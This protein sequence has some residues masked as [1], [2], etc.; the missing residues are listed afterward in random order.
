MS[1]NPAKSPCPPSCP[2]V[3]E[4]LR[5]AINLIN[6]LRKRCKP[7][8]IE[9]VKEL[10]NVTDGIFPREKNDVKPRLPPD[11]ISRD[12]PDEAAHVDKVPV[13]RDV[14]PEVL[15]DVETEP[16]VS[17]EFPTREPTVVPTEKTA[18]DVGEKIYLIEKEK[19]TEPTIVQ[20]ETV[21]VERIDRNEKRNDFVEEKELV[22]GPAVP[23][24]TVTP[25]ERLAD[26]DETKI[27]LVAEKELVEEPTIIPEETVTPTE[28]IVDL[29]EKKIDFVEEEAVTP[30]T[31]IDWEEEKIDLITEEKLDKKPVTVQEETVIPTERTADRDDEKIDFVEEED[32]AVEGIAAEPVRKVPITI[33]EPEIIEDEMKLAPT[34]KIELETSRELEEQFEPEERMEYGEEEESVTDYEKFID[35]ELQESLPAVIA[36]EIPEEPRAVRREISRNA[37]TLYERI[38]RERP[39][40]PPREREAVTAMPEERPAE[41]EVSARRALESST[42]EQ[43]VS[44][45]PEKDACEETCPLAKEQKE[46]IMRKLKVRQRVVDHYYL[47]K[48]FSYFED[49]CTCSLACMVYTLS[50]DPFVKSI[51]ASLAL[52][53]V[54]LKLCSELDAWEMP[55]RVS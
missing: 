31:K 43:I 24:E 46:R 53:A 33:E 32:R 54:G 22:P 5:I 9:T 1:C 7:S 51:F 30:P 4:Q 28:K 52:F 26:R 55:S 48:G 19:L 27:G 3:K 45:K 50:R 2:K 13:D 21:T 35:E 16:S 12:I 39:V 14:R 17:E 40:R 25:T 34:T 42:T 6:T 44:R 38:D 47:T 41:E 8:Q 37:A 11:V 18:D 10:P 20:E 23:K 29:D 15:K 36:R 49:V